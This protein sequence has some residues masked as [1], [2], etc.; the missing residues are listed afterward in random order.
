MHNSGGMT[1]PYTVDF[2][3][4][5]HVSGKSYLEPYQFAYG[6]E[7]LNYRRAT[8]KIPK[9]MSVGGKNSFRKA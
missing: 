1:V 5:L 3:L 2:A 9:Q 4:P 8:T 6:V 7:L